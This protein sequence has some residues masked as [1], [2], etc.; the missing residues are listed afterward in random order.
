MSR[1]PASLRSPAVWVGIALVPA[2]YFYGLN[3]RKKSDEQ[4]K[5]MSLDFQPTRENAEERLENLTKVRQELE[6][7]RDQIL[8]KLKR[9]EERR[10]EK[11]A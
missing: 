9:I 7:E 4:A 10:H 2:G 6:Q 5:S 8:A 3:A 11:G 1:I